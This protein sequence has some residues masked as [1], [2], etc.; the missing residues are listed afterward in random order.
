M[1]CE[2]YTEEELLQCWLWHPEESDSM[3]NDKGNSMELR[4]HD[5]IIYIC[6]CVSSYTSMEQLTHD[7]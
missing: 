2:K 3:L 5:I 1:T 6:D 4:A 7:F